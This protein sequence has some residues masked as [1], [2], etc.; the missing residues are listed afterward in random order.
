M[1]V[2]RADQAEVHSMHNV[3]FHSLIRP[4][5]GSAEICQWRLEIGAETVGQ[6]HRVLREETFIMLSGTAILTIDDESVTLGPGDAAVAPAESTIR[7][8]NSSDAPATLLVTV[9]VG[10]RAELADGTVFTPPWVG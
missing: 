10:F 2:I 6:P 7:L 1:P 5:T 4:A 8:D 9:P 3:R